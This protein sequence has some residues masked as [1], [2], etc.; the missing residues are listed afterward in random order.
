MPPLYSESLR[1]AARSQLVSASEH[2]EAYPRRSWPDECFK[3]ETDCTH[4]PYE[5]SSNPMLAID[6]WRDG[7]D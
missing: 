4:V 7:H 6:A 1:L 3:G 5:A 2:L